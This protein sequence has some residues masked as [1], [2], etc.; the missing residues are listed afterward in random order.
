[1]KKI[2]TLI[3]LFIAI[4]SFAQEK[5]GDQIIQFFK[6][7]IKID[8]QQESELTEVVANYLKN[9]AALKQAN[10]G[11]EEA[12]K[13]R[14]EHLNNSFDEKIKAILTEEQYQKYTELKT[15]KSFN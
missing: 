4:S 6:N 1:M 2:V 3:A 15:K 9:T 14:F 8:K 11:D 10:S 7:E 5:N 12:K 13:I